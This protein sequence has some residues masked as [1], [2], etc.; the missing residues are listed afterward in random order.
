MAKY[1]IL[2][3]W[4]DQGIR[5]VKDSP[6]RVDAVKAL[7]A[8]V[9]GKIDVWYTMGKFDFVAIAEAPNDEAYMQLALT[10]GAQG[11]ARTTT[12]KAWSTDDG[13]KVIA[14]I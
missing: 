5:N 11:N 1:I 2:G 14:K 9:G 6:K 8:K 13:A 7:A 10:I 3:Q 4:T 12:L